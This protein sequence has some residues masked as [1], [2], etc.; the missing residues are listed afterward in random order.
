L[1]AP[2]TSSLFLGH[3]EAK[4]ERA[5]LLSAFPYYIYTSFASTN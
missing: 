1:P 2:Q 4:R 3:S 5:Q